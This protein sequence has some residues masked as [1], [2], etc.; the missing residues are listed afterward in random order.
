MLVVDADLHCISPFLH[1][2]RRVETNVNCFLFRVD[3]FPNGLQ[4]E[5]IVLVVLGASENVVCQVVLF[6]G[7]LLLAEQNLPAV[8]QANLLLLPPLNAIAERVDISLH[9]V[10]PQFRRF[11]VPVA[12]TNQVYDILDVVVD[13]VLPF[14]SR[15][16]SH[17]VFGYLFF[18]F[19]EFIFGFGLFVI[20]GMDDIFAV[21]KHSLHFAPN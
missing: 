19:L 14:E 8:V 2:F 3:S 18:A 10:G 20:L 9:S 5:S 12:D 1:L 21:V 7:V 6:D 13:F 4:D 15:V 11:G 17:E 16:G